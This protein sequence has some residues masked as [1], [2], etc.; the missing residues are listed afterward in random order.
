MPARL[1]EPYQH[2]TA[3]QLKEELSKTEDL[4]QRLSSVGLTTTVTDIRIEHLSQLMLSRQP[5]GQQQ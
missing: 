3:A 1:P 4:R 5:A 2:L